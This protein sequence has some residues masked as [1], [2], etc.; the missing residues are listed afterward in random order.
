MGAKKSRCAAVIAA[1]LL[2]AS[3]IGPPSL[4]ACG[5]SQPKKTMA[6]QYRF[7][8]SGM[9][10]TPIDVFRD[11]LP[12]DVVFRQISWEPY[13]KFRATFPDG[14]WLNIVCTRA[15]SSASACAQAETG[16]TITYSDESV[17]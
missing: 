2:M 4:M 3:C 6:N 17:F 10:E 1:V 7:D 11:Q 12:P 9:R 14:S 5:I 13:E 16:R 15:A 8:I